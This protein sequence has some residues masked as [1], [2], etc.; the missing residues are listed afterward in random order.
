MINKIKNTTKVLVF[1]LLLSILV[2]TLSGILE[3]KISVFKYKDFYDDDTEMDV[4]FFGSS[5]M[6]NSVLPME[7]YKNYGITSYN[8]GNSC[9]TIPMSY[10][11]MKNA[12][13]YRKPKIIVLET[14]YDGWGEKVQE[15]KESFIH[16]FY[17]TVPFSLEKVKSIFELVGVEK[18]EEFLF[19]L[20]Y[21]NNRW[22]E[23]TKTDFVME[24]S[25]EKGGVSLVNYECRDYV[26]EKKDP[27]YQLQ[28]Y[29]LAEEYLD[30]IKKLCDKNDIKL[31]LYQAPYCASEFEVL[32]AEQYVNYAKENNIPILSILS[33]NE[34]NYK[35]DMADY[36]HLNIYGAGKN[37]LNFGK[38]LMENYSDI[39]KSK[40][41][42]RWNNDYKKYQEFNIDRFEKSEKIEDIILLSLALEYD[43]KVQ[44]GHNANNIKNNKIL[45]EYSKENIIDI[46]NENSEEDLVINVYDN[47]NLIKCFKFNDE[48]E[49]IKE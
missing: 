30:K 49:I 29:P 22:E 48:E 28:I 41:I 15:G 40:D 7:L 37:T 23:L 44:Y 25:T 45:N 21:Y 16:F 3:S 43:V 14:F 36:G 24:Y 10:Y 13:Q 1:F 39:L 6:M 11:V 12:I 35:T 33:S 42:D 8:C 9:E 20:T 32:L 17:D 18:S 46:I 2:T 19:N 27:G 34:I 4:L 47:D 38:Y 5:L 31:V 26:Y